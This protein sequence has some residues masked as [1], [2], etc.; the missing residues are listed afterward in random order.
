MRE[1]L[2][3]K[4]TKEMERLMRCIDAERRVAKCKALAHEHVMSKK[5]A[6]LAQAKNSRVPP[7]ALG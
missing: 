7:P 5:T 6:E 4:M 2:N 1:Y 3:L